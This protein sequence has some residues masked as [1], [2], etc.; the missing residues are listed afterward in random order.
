MGFISVIQSVPY[1]QQKT[2]QIRDL[3]APTMYTTFLSA[4]SFENLKRYVC[5]YSTR[6]I[7]LRDD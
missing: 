3:I 2:K 1:I 7:K 4:N 5:D 6:D